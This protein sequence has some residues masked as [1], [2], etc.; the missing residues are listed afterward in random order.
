MKISDLMA[1]VRTEPVEVQGLVTDRSPF[2]KL[3]ANGLARFVA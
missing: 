3:R 2:D 1:T